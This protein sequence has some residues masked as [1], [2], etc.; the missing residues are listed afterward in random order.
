[1]TSKLQASVVVHARATIFSWPRSVV[2]GA[3]RRGAVSYITMT[4]AQLSS[5][6]ANSRHITG[7]HSEL[8]GR[9]TRPGPAVTG[10]HR[11]DL[12][13]LYCELTVDLLP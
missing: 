5:H 7:L 4:V 2:G 12:S 1:M 3:V 9:E 10:L 13:V 11:L 6:A 8:D